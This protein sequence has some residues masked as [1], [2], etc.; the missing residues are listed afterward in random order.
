MF[1][2][3]TRMS[4]EAIIYEV[5][6]NWNAFGGIDMAISANERFILSGKNDI[7]VAYLIGEEKNK[8]FELLFF[9]LLIMTFGKVLKFAIKA[10]WGV[11]KIVVSV[12]LLPIALIGLVLQGLLVIALPILVIIGVLAIIVLHD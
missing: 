8:M 6:E 10:A 11:S 1:A 7:I 12:V 9:V 3:V 4:Y 5:K 2:S